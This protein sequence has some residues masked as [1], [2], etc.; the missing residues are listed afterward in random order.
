MDHSWGTAF[1]LFNLGRI[2]LVEG[3]T[4]RA[5]EQLQES[6]EILQNMKERALLPD[7][8]FCLAYTA[9]ALNDRQQA[10]RFMI[11]S[12]KIVIETQP[13]NPM[14]FELPGMALLLADQGK[15]ERAIEFYAAALKS[16]YIANSRWFE[17]LVGNQIAELGASLPQDAVTAAQKRGQARD[18]WATV[19]AILAE[20]SE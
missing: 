14:R 19:N 2:D 9:C 5:W 13:L 15:A 16:P 1:T 3:I 7:V 17:D 18:L 6:A 10:I 8:L 20:L 4:D 11:Q 12:L